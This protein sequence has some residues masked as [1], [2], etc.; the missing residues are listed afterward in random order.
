MEDIQNTQTEFLEL[1][2]R[3]LDVKNIPDGI[4]DRL[5]IA[6]KRSENLKEQ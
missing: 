3:R 5:D 4:K 6:E 1:E 2:I